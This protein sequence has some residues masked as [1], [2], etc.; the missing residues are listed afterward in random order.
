[1]IKLR[2]DKI[3]KCSRLEISTLWLPLED[4]DL[5]YSLD[6]P[7]PKVNSTIIPCH[8]TLEWVEK[9]WVELNWVELSWIELSWVE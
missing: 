3:E 8:P 7:I 4:F 2:N 6:D 5:V 9:S 1:M